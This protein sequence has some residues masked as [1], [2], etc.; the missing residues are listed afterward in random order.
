LFARKI[1]EANV[2]TTTQKLSKERKR[3]MLERLVT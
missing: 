1:S 3:L 2:Q